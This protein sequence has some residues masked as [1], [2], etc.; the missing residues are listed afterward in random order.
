MANQTLI[1]KLLKTPL[2]FTPTDFLS[3]TGDASNPL[4]N[5]EI[6]NM[7]LRIYD[8]TEKQLQ[9]MS[10][11]NDGTLGTLNRKST[12]KRHQLFDKK[13]INRE[14]NIDY[15]MIYAE[16]DSWFQFPYF[17]HDIVDWLDEEDNYLVRSDA[18]GGDWFTNIIYEQQYVE[19]LSL[20]KPDVFLI[21]GGGNDMVGSN[22]LAYLV[23]TNHGT[24]KY[25]DKSQI[26]DPTTSNDHK[27][28]IMSAQPHISKEFY[29][30]VW[31][32][33]AQYKILFDRIYKEGS[34]HAH[35]ISITQG[36][37]YVF[38]S[39]ENRFS[40]KNPLQPIVNSFEGTGRWLFYPLMM[41]GIT[42]KNLQRAIV[43]TFIYEYNQMFIELANE[44]PHVYH[45]DCR[46]VAPEYNDWY[47]EL[48]LTS[49]NFER[50]AYAYKYIINNYKDGGVP[51]VIRVVGVPR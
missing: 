48:H 33:K 13:I 27:D 12:E 45:V 9:E 4:T 51:K 37:D 31:I 17:V 30:L 43:M 1:E 36:Y 7:I 25:T 15:K 6:R 20:Y 23:D 26:K 8:L 24:A 49:E 2:E 16:G 5:E 29:A 42:D 11:A 41:R 22:R 38:P 40:W 32:M 47:D 34:K 46:G 44:Y 21:S 39:N 50:V 28:M 14:P 35:M 19:G 3:L 18:Y 10:N